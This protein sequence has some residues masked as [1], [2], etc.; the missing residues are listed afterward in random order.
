MNT[1]DTFSSFPLEGCSSDSTHST[2]STHC[3]SDERIL[4]PLGDGGT[5]EYKAVQML[6]GLNIP[7]FFLVIIK[8]NVGEVIKHL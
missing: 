2:H 3:L 6:L 5:I 8:L 7:A 1:T 4:V